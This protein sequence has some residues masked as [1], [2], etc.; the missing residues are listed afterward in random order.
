MDFETLRERALAF[1]EDLLARKDEIAP[2]DFGWYPYD[3]MANI[4]HLDALL[5]GPQRQVFDRIAG[6]RI[7]DIG[8]ADGDFGFFLEAELGCQVDVIDNAPTNFNGLRGARRLVAE[9]DSKVQVHEI[10][11]DAQFELPAE[12]YGAVF[13][14][15]LLYHLKNPFFVLERL[16]E[17]ADLCFVSTRIA[18]LTPDGTRIQ[19]QPV[20]YL[21]DPTEAN[22]DA[23]NFWI[24]SEAGLRRLFDR[25]GWEV[26]DFTT[27]GCTQDS[28]PSA[29]DRDERAFALLRSKKTR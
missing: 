29:Q 14:L 10:D 28:N 15:G 18:Q 1:R 13:F 22:N 2:S 21:L 12:H 7:A 25:A 26:V 27:V 16:A 6:T 23:T 4:F 8:A 17:R 24:F 3:T 9:L 11:L 20:A 5:S 19:Q